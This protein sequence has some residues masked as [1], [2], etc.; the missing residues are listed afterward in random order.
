VAFRGDATRTFVRGDQAFSADII[1]RA[2]ASA[3]RIVELPFT[4][5]ANE[6]VDDQIAHN[7]AYGLGLPIVGVTIL[8]ATAVDIR[9]GLF[10]L[11]FVLYFGGVPGAQFDARHFFHLEFITLW[12]IGLLVQGAITRLPAAIRDR[13]WP[14]APLPLGRAAM[15]LAG[16]A[17]VLALLLSAAR[18]YQQPP[19]GRSSPTIWRRLARKCPS[20]APRRT[21]L[22]SRF[23]SP[24]IPIPKPPTSS[25]SISRPRAAA[26]TPP[27]GSAMTTPCASSTRACSPS[28]GTPGT[29]RLAG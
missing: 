8:L 4:D 25:P 2:Y 20:T 27:S 29:L 16:C 17:A 6:D 28:A 9:V 18:V 12:A 10:L 11:F 22:R 3:R 1:V 23:A 19:R 13:E 7:R 15:I 5:R 14:I 24:R 26:S 21:R